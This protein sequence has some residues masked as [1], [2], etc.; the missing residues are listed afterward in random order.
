MHACCGFNVKLLIIIRSHWLI[1]LSA[2]SVQDVLLACLLFELQAFVKDLLSGDKLTD[3]LMWQTFFFFPAFLAAGRGDGV[4]ELF[5]PWLICYKRDTDLA[6][7]GFLSG[8]YFNFTQHAARFG[9]RLLSTCD[10]RNLKWQVSFREVDLLL[11]FLWPEV[12]VRWCEEDQVISRSRGAPLHC[13]PFIVLIRWW[14]SRHTEEQQQNILHQQRRLS[15]S[16]H[17]V[18]W[19]AVCSLSRRSHHISLMHTP[20]VGQPWC[21]M[22]T[23]CLPPAISHHCLRHFASSTNS[24]AAVMWVQHSTALKGRLSLIGAS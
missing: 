14:R 15:D 3:L 16:S 17:S 21:V 2:W 7:L 18:F 19:L 5:V 22:G 6:L 12:A 13:C 11:P 8:V 10:R 20:C 4:S 1:V 23:Q 9:C 24:V